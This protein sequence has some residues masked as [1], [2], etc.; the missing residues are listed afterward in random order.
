MLY[1]MFLAVSLISACAIYFYCGYEK[2]M[3]LP[4]GRDSQKKK[5]EQ[6]ATCFS[7][8]VS[9]ALSGAMAVVLFLA[10]WSLYQNTQWVGF[11]K[12][13]GLLVIVL[14]AGMID[15][16]RKII[17]NVLVLFG[18]LSYSFPFNLFSV[19]SLA[20]YFLFFGK[21]IVNVFPVS[22]RLN[23]RR[24]FKKKPKA[25]ASE[26]PKVVPWRCWP[27]APRSGCGTSEWT[28]G[29]AWRWLCSSRS[30]ASAWPGRPYRPCWACGQTRS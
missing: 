6:S 13:F 9:I 10:Q 23:A 24:L 4:F 17:P 25:K 18:L 7:L 19:I 8:P 1:V 26:G 3:E 11:V 15:F 12:L 27:A 29:W 20:N 5:P 28:A 30:P 14:C 21:D 2:V 16:K 22:W